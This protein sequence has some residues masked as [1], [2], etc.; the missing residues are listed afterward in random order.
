MEEQTQRPAQMTTNNLCALTPQAPGSHFKLRIA[1][2]MLAASS[3]YYN[4]GLVVAR[5][6]AKKGG[7]DEGVQAT[8]N[9]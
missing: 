7:P 9:K 3:L 2:R 4:S 6:N 1:Y 8:A 5:S